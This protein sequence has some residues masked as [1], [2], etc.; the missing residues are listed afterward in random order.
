MLQLITKVDQK[1]IEKIKENGEGIQYA[2]HLLIDKQPMIKCF[3]KFNNIGQLTREGLI[4]S[5]A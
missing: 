5:T 2:K 1:E 3:L 4:L